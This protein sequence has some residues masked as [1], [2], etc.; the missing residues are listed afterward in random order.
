MSR[1]C[2]TPMSLSCA[3]E[4]MKIGPVRR[5]LLLGGG[6]SLV[7]VAK[8]ARNVGLSA[9]AIIAPR[10]AKDSIGA[11]T[12]EDN[13]RLI[14]CPYIETERLQTGPVKEF[15]GSMDD[16]IA[17]SFGAAWIFSDNTIKSLFGG[18][19]FNLHGTRLPQNRG[20]GGFSWQIMMGNRLGFCVMHRVDEG[21]DTGDIIRFDEFIY[22]HTCRKPADFMDFYRNRLVRFVTEF[23]LEV[24][25][26]SVTI[27][28]LIQPEYFSTYWP[29]LSTDL[30]SWIDWSLPIHQLERF[31]CAFD[32]PYSG[33]QST[34][35]DKTISI[36]SCV[37]DFNDPLSH[38][39]QYGLIYR[40]NGKWL[41]IAANGGTL[42]IEKVLL[43]GQDITAA[44]TVG[45]RFFT[46][47]GRLSEALTSRV[48]YTPT[49]MKH[50]NV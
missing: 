31:M 4:K 10:H 24:C 11:G 16:A 8:A 9:C 43:D 38:P 2:H 44:I 35:N 26:E 36:K 47:T 33:A 14:G 49:G 17:I 21:I 1:S 15:I 7:Q 37:S 5:I 34:W 18:K 20:G 42:I 46:P 6:S 39:F 40:N 3:G 30:H 22:P 28:P 27:K 13:L 29:R 23:L 19:L 45:D 32:D 12:L 50:R 25:H 48:V 41:S